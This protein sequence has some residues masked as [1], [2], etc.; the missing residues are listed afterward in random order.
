MGTVC[1]AEGFF[2]PND[3]NACSV[4]NLTAAVEVGGTIP[5]PAG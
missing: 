3:R 4:S 2:E 1:R 5:S